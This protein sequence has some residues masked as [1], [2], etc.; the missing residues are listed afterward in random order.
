[1]VYRGP[2]IVS[3]ISEELTNILIESITNSNLRHFYGMNA[4]KRFE[5]DLNANIVTNKLIDFIKI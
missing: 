3:K 2:N 1:M 5:T 4:L